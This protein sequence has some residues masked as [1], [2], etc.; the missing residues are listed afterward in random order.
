MGN[1]R[2]S[3][4]IVYLKFVALVGVIHFGISI[5][6]WLIDVNSHLKVP[7]FEIDWVMLL[8]HG[9][10]AVLLFLL[11][12]AALFFFERKRTV[13]IRLLFISLSVTAILFFIETQNDFYQMSTPITQDLIVPTGYTLSFNTWWWYHKKK[14]MFDDNYNYLYGYI[15]KAGN[16]TIEP[17]YEKACP[18]S[19]GYA[20]VMKDNQWGYINQEG[21]IVIQYEFETAGH[22]SDGI[23]PVKQGDEWFYIDTEGNR[24]FD[25]SFSK[26]WSFSEGRAAVLVRGRW[27][28]IDREGDF[29]VEPQY[30]KVGTFHEGAAAVFQNEL[31][32]FIDQSG[33][34]ILPYSYT[35]AMSFSDGI[36]PVE[37]N[38]RWGY[39]DKSGQVVIEPYYDFADP[40][41]DGFAHIYILRNKWG[42]RKGK[43]G[44]YI[45]RDGKIIEK[46]NQYTSAYSDNLF[47]VRKNDKDGY[48]NTKGQWVIEPRYDLATSFSDGLAM[49]RIIKEK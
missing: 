38:K 36:A 21:N 2:S 11:F 10:P 35:K 47:V 40:F 8:L 5:S 19:D 17:V 44:G 18:F 3:V 9:L 42:Y 31:Y 26:A 12:G 6:F 34:L 4:S 39:I 7:F 24:L 14:S 23:A 41:K 49:V 46:Y 15:D 33:E 25:K 45:N 32:G 29:A 37:I 28:Y 43:G 20:A 16:Y 22:F 30:E 27:G 48:K 13:S 1:T